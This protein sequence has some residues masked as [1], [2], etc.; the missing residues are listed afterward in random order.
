MALIRSFRDLNVYKTARRETQKIFE[1]S[2]N[3]PAEERYSLTDQIRRS[4]RAVH[5]AKQ[6]KRRLGSMTASIVAIFLKLNSFKWTLRGKVLALC[7]TK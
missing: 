7:S 1:R 2:R 5:L 4:S 3:F 6:L